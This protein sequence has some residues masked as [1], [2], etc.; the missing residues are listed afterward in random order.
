MTGCASH[1]SR[2]SCD[3]RSPQ[4]QVKATFKAQLRGE[5]SDNVDMRDQVLTD[6]RVEDKRAPF[7]QDVL[8]TT[9]AN[10]ALAL[11][12]LTTGI[13]AAR[14]LGPSGRGEL[15]AIQLWANFIAMI[16]TLG[17]SEALVY[18]S[19]RRTDYT[20]R[21]LGS[22]V[23]L[24]A[25]A[26]IPLCAATCIYMPTLLAAEPSQIITAARWY[27]FAIPLSALGGLPAYCLRGLKQFTLWN[28]FRLA[29]P[30]GTLFVLAIAYMTRRLEPEFLAA[31]FLISIGLINCV[32][33][34]I[35]IKRIKGPLLLK[36]EDWRPMLRFGLPSAITATPQMLNL[37]LDQILMAAFLPPSLLGLYVVAVGYSGVVQPLISAIGAVHFPNVASKP[38]WDSKVNSF[39]AVSRIAALLSFLLV[40]FLAPLA[41][42]GLVVLFG[43]KFSPATSAVMVLVL[44][45]GVLGLNSILQEGLKGLGAPSAV[46]WAELGGLPVTL[47]SLALLLK[48]LGILGAA[49]SS[50]LG[51]STVSILLVVQAKATTGCSLSTLFI[52]RKTELGALMSQLVAIVWRF[53]RL[54]VTSTA[55]YGRS[56]LRFRE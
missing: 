30:A 41:P 17:L 7:G 20:G 1:G 25:L 11:F 3:N 36:S 5:K 9:C 29:A 55:V 37:K 24:S 47:V 22:A 39:A 53:Q 31:G 46:M 13:L 23:V 14:L 26:G 33:W 34:Y 8:V 21:Y 43:S 54:Y 16:A 35:T 42:L 51:Y 52:A 38:D 40:L 49:F 27:L 28:Y 12:G 6:A 18:F 15:A 50:L 19:A 48:P 45:A 56:P 4:R 10:G 44:A 2:D 32:L